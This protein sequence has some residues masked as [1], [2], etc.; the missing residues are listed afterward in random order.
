MALSPPRLL[1]TLLAAIAISAIFW[2]RFAIGQNMP[3]ATGAA[4]VVD[5]SHLDVAGQ[6]FK[7]YGIDAPDADEICQEAKGSEYPCGIEA[8]EALVKLASAGSVSCL[9]RGPNALNEMLAICT[10][11]QT[12]IARALVEAGWAIAD[13]TRTLYYEDL[14][15]AARTAKRGLWRGPFVAPDAWRIGER[16]PQSRSGI[17]IPKTEP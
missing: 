15:L 6:R 11:G 4:T 2:V 3:V 12:D 10:V 8:R 5:A 16:V 13:R 9:P 14:E 7:L 17:N 1:P